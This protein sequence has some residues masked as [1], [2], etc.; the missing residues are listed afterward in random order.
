MRGIQ[1]RYVP[2]TTMDI[3]ETDIVYTTYFHCVYFCTA[4]AFWQHNCTSS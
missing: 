2:Y 4:A 3:H 1:F